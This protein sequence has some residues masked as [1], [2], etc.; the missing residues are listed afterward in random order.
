[1]L[2]H[3]QADLPNLGSV[4]A[5]AAQDGFRAW[6][7]SQDRAPVTPLFLDYQFQF[8]FQWLSPSEG[9]E[10]TVDG[11]IA[12]EIQSPQQIHYLFQGLA[13]FGDKPPVHFEC[14]LLLDG[15]FFW[16]SGKTGPDLTNAEGF[17]VKGDQVL[18]HDL[19]DQYLDFL[20]VMAKTRDIKNAG[21]E[22][23]IVTILDWLPADLETYMHPAGYMRFGTRI[24][25]CRRILN[26]DGI[27]DADM[28]LDM[29]RDSVLGMVI[30]TLESMVANKDLTDAK[31]ARDLRFLRSLGEDLFAHIR[32]DAAT[33]TPLGMDLNLAMDFP[34]DERIHEDSSMRMRFRSDSIARASDQLAQVPFAISVGIEDAYDVTP[35]LQMAQNRMQAFVDEVESK[36]DAD[37]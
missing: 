6:M 7:D 37:F 14:D 27:V 28:T 5:L 3:H 10:M 24:M 2:A 17:L 30:S 11:S 8:E 18:L 19:Y 35:F 12:T 20:P 9:W 4:E 36:E 21:M 15:E 34:A 23:S 22:E 1:M 16:V 25:T 26:K 31:T 33:G 13:V 29:S 32:F